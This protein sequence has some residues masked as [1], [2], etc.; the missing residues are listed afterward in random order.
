MDFILNWRVTA[1]AIA[2]ETETGCGG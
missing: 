1:R 2:R